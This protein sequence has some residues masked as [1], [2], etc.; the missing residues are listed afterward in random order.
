[1]KRTA[2]V[3][4]AGQGIGLAIAG[5]LDKA[6]YNVIL[7]DIGF[8][9]AC[10]AA[11]NLTS[12]KAVYL[13]VCSVKSIEEA[14]AEGADAFGGIDVLVNNAGLLDGPDYETLTEQEWD[15]IQNVNIKGLFFCIQ[16]ALPYLRKAALPR[17]INI[18]S[19]AGKMGS[20]ASGMSYVSSKG[21]VLS[22]TRGLSRR[23]APD[24]ITVNAVMPGPIPTKHN[25][26]Y[27]AQEATK[28]ELCGRIPMKTYG[29]PA[30]IA[31]AVVY[32]LGERAGWT[33]GTT[34]PVDGG[35]L[36]K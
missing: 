9:N 28:E 10:R 34:L 12:A 22:L 13:D 35:Y 15:R 6:G 33:T 29:D 24:G 4:G 36:A 11:G 30:N 26:A 7:A 8:E 20:Y 18:S 1:M 27:L 32:F 5:R 14:L 21:A 17:I 23:L 25:S 16:K 2:F 31:D 3:T 19:I